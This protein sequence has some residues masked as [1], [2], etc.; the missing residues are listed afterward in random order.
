MDD[1]IVVGEHAD[2]RLR[3][4]GENPEEAAERGATRMALPVFTATITTV[5][6]FA[7]LVFST[8]PQLNITFLSNPDKPI[9]PKSLKNT[10]GNII[11]GNTAAGT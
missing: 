10:P 6:A 4:L 11:A 7:G 3:R 8:F 2:F 9:E 1:A 5:I